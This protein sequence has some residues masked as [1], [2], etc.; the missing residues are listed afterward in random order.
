MVMILVL[1]RIVQYQQSC[2]TNQLGIN[3]FEAST[4]YIYKT[5][6]VVVYNTETINN[7]EYYVP[8]TKRI[9]TK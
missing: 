4:N 8:V 9:E 6:P 5:T 3:N 2:I 1:Y 7:K